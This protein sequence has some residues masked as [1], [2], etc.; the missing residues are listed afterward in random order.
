MWIF[1]LFIVSALIAVAITPKPDTQAVTPED[2]QVPQVGE[3]DE[4]PVLFG[5]RDIRS[6]HV[7]WYG[8]VKTVAV[9]KKAG[10]K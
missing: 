10:K 7:V 3:G 9:R 4:I 6:P 2:L 5:T 8:D 1:I